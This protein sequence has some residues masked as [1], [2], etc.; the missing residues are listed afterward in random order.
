MSGRDKLVAALATVPGLTATATNP[1]TPVAG[2]AW[3]VWVMARFQAGKLSHPYVN[4]YD[5]HVVLPSG[6]IA[7]TVESG[8]GFVP[9]VAA[10]LKTVGLVQTAEPIAIQVAD[11]STMP[12]LRIRV[13]PR[14]T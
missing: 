12:A 2:S 1:D 4:D 13:T 11:S 8:D 3:P 6:Y 14:E 9:V 7:T 5:V 10:A